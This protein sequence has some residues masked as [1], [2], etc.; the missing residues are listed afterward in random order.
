M[1][2]RANGSRSS[3]MR[4]G[5][6]RQAHERET[7]AGRGSLGDEPHRPRAVRRAAAIQALVTA[8]T[9]PPTNHV[10][11][12]QE[13][14]A[15]HRRRPDRV[16]R[17]PRGDGGDRARRQQL[18]LQS[19]LP[20]AVA[21]AEQLRHE[22]RVDRQQD[23][24]RHL[25]AEAPGHADPGDD[26]LLAPA[27]EQAEVDPPV[28]A[29]DVRRVGRRRGARARCTRPSTRAGSAARGG[30]RS[31]GRCGALRCRGGRRRTA[32]RAGTPRGRR[33][34][35]RRCPGGRSRRR[36]SARG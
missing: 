17:R 10:H 3:P 1:E 24:E 12:P 33:R 8:S 32:G 35:P 2:L 18:Q 13:L 30:A 6:E 28:V 21:A 19:R 25:D 29:E 7:P 22:Q 26:R 20:V 27:L 4:P 16:H 14:V 34:S 23:V 5:G 11:V 9:R 15:E 36:G 31:G